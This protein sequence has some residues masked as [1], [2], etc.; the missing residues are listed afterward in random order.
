MGLAVWRSWSWPRVNWYSVCGVLLLIS[1][2]LG[3]AWG[4]RLLGQTLA[5]AERLPIDEIALVGQRSYTR[6]IEVRQALSA[7]EGDSLVTADME[8]VRTALTRLPWVNRVTVRREWPNRL[9]LYLVEQRPMAHWNGGDWLNQDA[10]VFQ[11]PP[12]SGIGALPQLAGPEGSSEKVWQ[13]WLKFSELLR[14]N[15]FSPQRL[16]L[17]HRH[18]WTLTLEDG[19]ELRLGRIEGIE[20][21][22]RFIELWPTLSRQGRQAQY[23]D[24]RYDTGLAVGWQLE[25]RD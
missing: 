17:S 25:Q 2:L 22:Q 9:R 4:G 11:A 13:N 21:L 7:I 20:R 3:L 23:I 15:G 8:K 16:T 6:D 10:Q 19:L 24:I 1:V 14:L 12:R 18:A 5:D